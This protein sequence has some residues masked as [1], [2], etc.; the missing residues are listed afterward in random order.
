[1]WW[2]RSRTP[3]R[4]RTM[5]VT[6][7]IPNPNAMRTIPETN[8]MRT[9]PEPHEVRNMAAVRTIPSSNDTETD[10]E[11]GNEGTTRGISM[12][13]KAQTTGNDRLKS[14]FYRFQIEWI[15]SIESLLKFTYTIHPTCAT[16]CLRSI[17][18]HT[19]GSARACQS[20]HLFF[21]FASIS[22]PRVGSFWSMRMSEKNGRANVRNVVNP[23][24]NHLR[25]L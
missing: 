13:S 20:N 1:M 2:E 3:M 21:C 8:A 9:I 5:N 18:T 16:K 19:P 7:T 23:M 25:I 4:L 11:T 10:F 22:G 12:A 24:A 17:T 14:P 6:R 15:E